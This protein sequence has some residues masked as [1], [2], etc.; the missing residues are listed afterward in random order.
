MC[1]LSSYA[2]VLY[3][4]SA[5]RYCLAVVQEPVPQSRE[6]NSNPGRAREEQRPVTSSQKGLVQVARLPKW[7]VSLVHRNVKKHRIST[8]A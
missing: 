7:V 8:I 3:R 1:Y 2:A 5:V 4:A 6:R